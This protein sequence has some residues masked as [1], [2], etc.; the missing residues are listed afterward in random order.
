MTTHS[1]DLFVGHVTPLT[2]SRVG[3][4]EREDKVWIMDDAGRI[5]KMEVDYSNTVEEVLPECQELAKVLRLIK[6]TY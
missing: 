5:V 6:I 1:I 4:Q 3:F 2:L